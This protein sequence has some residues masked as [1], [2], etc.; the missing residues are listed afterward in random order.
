MNRAETSRVAETSLSAG[1]RGDRL[2]R[3]SRADS[4]PMVDPH[5]E[6]VPTGVA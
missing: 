2:G 1:H 5:P 6:R 3:G 4:K